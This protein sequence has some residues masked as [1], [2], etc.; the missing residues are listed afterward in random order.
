MASPSSHNDQKLFFV[1]LVH[2]I[3]WVFFVCVIGYV[4]YAG[5]YNQI[6]TTVWIAIGLVILEGIVILMNDGKCPLTDI[7]GRYT[8]D[9]ND[10]FDIFL[11]NWLAKY[12]KLIFTSIFAVGV[13]LV[14][15]RVL[16]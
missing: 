11:P 8:T 16:Q 13:V 2:T 9:R 6:G 15:Y 12:N 14:L 10:A 4:V 3:I 1:K 5:I 7:G